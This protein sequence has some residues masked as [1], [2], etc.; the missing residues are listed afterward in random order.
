MRVSITR[1]TLQALGTIR[2]GHADAEGDTGATAKVARRTRRHRSLGPA[3]IAWLLLSACIPTRAPEA[4]ST[5]RAYRPRFE[6][7][8]CPTDPW[9]IGYLDDDSV[10]TCGYLIVPEDRRDPSGRTVR[11]FVQILEP[12]QGVT[13]PVAALNVGRD[14]GWAPFGHD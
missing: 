7:T 4:P 5:D 8:D 2:N 6:P 9:V 10:V 11:D 13:D 1:S 3:L 12:P 14:V